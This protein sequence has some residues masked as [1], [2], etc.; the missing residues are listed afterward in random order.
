M[1][2]LPSCSLLVNSRKM[3]SAVN[4]CQHSQTLDSYKSVLLLLIT[5]EVQLVIGEVTLKNILETHD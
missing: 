1:V 5:L 4:L 2:V 3:D